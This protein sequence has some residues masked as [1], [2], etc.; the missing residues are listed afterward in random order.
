MKFNVY[1]VSQYIIKINGNVY[2]KWHFVKL[3]SIAYCCKLHRNELEISANCMIFLIKCVQRVNKK[4]KL[5]LYWL[6]L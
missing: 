4:K 1:S 6:N 3:N 2:A 5:V